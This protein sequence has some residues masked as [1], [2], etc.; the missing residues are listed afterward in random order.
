[1]DSG[2]W[3]QIEALLHSM[4]ECQ[5]EERDAFLR[6]A[7]AGDETLEREVRSLMNWHE[8]AGEFLEKPAIEPDSL[9]GQ[10]ISHYRIIEKLGGGGMGVVYKAEDIRLQ[11]FVGLK[12]L[13]DGLARNPEALNRFRREA[14]A[15]S[16]LNHPN[17]STIYDIGEQAGQPFIAMEF[18]DGT[19]LKQRIASG[20]LENETIVSVAIEIADGLEAAHRAGI[21]HRDIKPANIFITSRG[22]AKILDFGLAKS[23]SMPGET[24]SLTEL[25]A[26]GTT[27]GTVSYMSPEQVRGKDLDARTDLFSLGVTLYEMAT[28]HL[29]FRGE[30]PAAI[31]DSILNRIPTPPVRLNPD[32]PVELERIIGK[33]LEKDRELRYQH[34]AEIRTDLQRMKRDTA[35]VEVPRRTRVSWP[36]IAAAGVV[37]AASSAALYFYLHRAPKLTD[38]DTIVLADFDNK[39]GDP[40]FDETLRRGLS[41]QLQQSPYLSLV[42]DQRIQRTLRLMAEPADARLTLPISRDICQ[43]A[44]A[45]AVLDGSIVAVGSVYVLALRATNCASGDVLDQEQ[46]QASRKEEVL[47]TLSQIAKKFRTRIGESLATVNQHSTPLREATTPSLDALKAYSMAMKLDLSQGNAA[48]IPFYQRALEIDPN[49]AM[50]NADLG[51]ALSGVGESVKS[52]EATTRA[53][54]LRDRAS[55]YE[56]FFIT[57]MWYRQVIGDLEKER[58]TVE[59]WAQTYP[60]EPE[61]HGLL[62][63]FATNGTG[64]YEEAIA[65]G[66]ATIKLDPDFI[67]GYE[68]A[69]QGCFYLNRFGD[70]E[71]NLRQASQHNLE[72]PDFHN[73]LYYIAFIRADEA[74]MNRQYNLA[75]KM[76]AEDSLAHARSLVLARSGRVRE[77]RESSE[78]AI[79]LARGKGDQ[80]PAAAYKSAE[81]VWDALYGNAP[82]AKRNAA[83][84]LD[85]S[86]GRD[87]EYAAAFALAAAGDVT[88][89]QTLANDLE[90]RFP[91]DTSVRFTYMPVLRA[92]YA[93]NRSQA[94]D[95]IKRLG[96]AAPYELSMNALDYTDF[97][98]GLYTVYVRGEAYLALRK[99][100]EAA[101]EFQKI[102]DHPG[103]VIADPVGALAH[104]QLGRAF[105]LSGD[106]AKAKSAYQDFLA[107]WKNADAD[108]PILAQ[109][110][111]EF[112]KL[113]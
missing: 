8:R 34:A 72:T 59:L 73:F 85:L 60:R 25:T 20:Q 49:F 21:V 86:K 69:A 68:N 106:Q 28:G 62:S 26:T 95:A 47:D 37:L 87:V 83:A 82:E 96:T 44:G 1:M 113:R 57:A 12:F 22:A 10:T 84:A 39:T 112:T 23:G 63:G 31:F 56:R 79:E 13:S 74:E 64:R 66:K 93:L 29:P 94:A 75:Q 80:E 89:S 15:A 30:G 43:R 76:G 104:L 9:V 16:A 42:S 14:R 36:S 53:W 102:L 18:L 91:E 98:G 109:A 70:A 88:A 35:Q 46:A 45:T 67:Y 90:T 4:T 108:I 107:L 3:K 40:V 38:K 11:R 27:L 7:C 6:R 100:P 101:A 77:A 41:V 78:R 110:K 54:Q 61:P 99:G 97:F 2:R 32:I 24:A 65:E 33:C 58:Q 51:L 71:E 103:I 111:A 105:V 52:A 55:D 19:T 50:A 17:I 5:P 92:L 81:A 48:G